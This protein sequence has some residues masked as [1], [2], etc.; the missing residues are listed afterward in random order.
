MTAVFEAAPIDNQIFKFERENELDIQFVEDE[1]A[2]GQSTDLCKNFFSTAGCLKGAR[3]QYRHARNDR[4]I[5]CKHWLRGLCKKGEYCEYLHEF[6]KSKMPECY[7][8][9]KFGEC[10]NPECA[11]RHVD[12]DKK[13]N[14]C[15]YYARGFCKHGPKCRLRHVKRE[16]CNDYL[17]GFC[18]NGPDCVFGHARF[19]IPRVEDDEDGPA[20]IDRFGFGRPKAAA[21]LARANSGD[22]DGSADNEQGDSSTSRGPPGGVGNA[23]QRGLPGSGNR[24]PF[25]G[26]GGP[27][28]LPGG[29]IPGIGMEGNLPF[30][31]PNQAMGMGMN[32]VF[33][34]GDNNTQ[35]SGMGGNRQ[36]DGGRT[37]I[38]CHHCHQPGHIRPK[39]PLRAAQLG[40]NPGGAT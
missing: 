33:D 19:E 32:P 10:N 7:F 37:P 13:R 27:P 26:M 36:G 21:G 15:P 31:A 17:L 6:D 2:E 11:Y 18:K 25:G 35:M 4:L 20:G 40:N 24:P 23:N 30:G 5:V 3:C 14:E 1:S 9:S 29:F 16:A 12:P 39:C 38:V 28:N 8:F 22:A 34:G